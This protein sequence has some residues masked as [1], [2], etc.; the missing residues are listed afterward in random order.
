[1][2]FYQIKSKKYQ[3]LINFL[4]IA[5]GIVVLSGLLSV[6]SWYKPSIKL[7][8]ISPVTIVLD[9]D[10]MVIDKFNT[11]LARENARHEAIKNT[12]NK[13][14]FEIDKTAQEES[15]NKLK[16]AI[17]V[18]RNTILNIEPEPDPINPKVNIDA[19]N[20]FLAIDDD[21]FNELLLTDDLNALIEDKQFY[22]DIQI[23]ED[24]FTPLISS[25]IRRLKDI[26]LKYFFSELSDLRKQISYQEKI[27]SQLEK[28]FFEKIKQVNYESIFR[29]AFLVQ[30]KL[31]DLGIVRG[32]P[33]QKVIENIQILFPNIP[34]DN[35]ELIS[36]LINVTTLPNI[37]IDWQKVNELENEAVKEVKPILTELKSGSILAKKG[38]GI[39]EQNYYY[40]K[41]LNM[42]NP[43]TDWR[44]I[45]ENFAI[46]LVVSLIILIA[47]LFN[48]N[49]NFAVN[50]VAMIMLVPVAVSAIIAPV[51]VWG[52]SKLAL[53]PVATIS[54]LMTTF[55][56]PMMGLI[57]VNIVCFFLAKTIDMNFWQILPQYI[58]A[59]AAILF[60]RNAHQREDL[61]NAGTKIAIIQVS[62]F[63]LTIMLA[64]EDFKVTTVLIVASL[65]AIG[66]IASGFISVAALPYL[67]SGL[68][69]ITPF[70]LSELSNPNQP[71][72]KKLKKEAPGTYEHS[73]NVSRL[74]EEA[75]NALNL[76]TELI[77]VGL[78]YH[79][80]GKMHAPDYFIENTLGKPNPHTTLDNP[81]KSAEIIID[82][83][84]EGIKM[85]KKYNLPA[86]IVDFIPMHQGTT[87]TNFFYYKAIEN[88]GEKNVDKELFR[89]PGPKPN[90]KE[91]GVAMIADSSEAAL[92]SIKDIADEE[93]A[94]EMI[95]KIVNSRWEEGELN[96]SGLTSADLDVI[97]QSFLKVWR[98]QNHER[99][100]YPEKKEEPNEEAP[101]A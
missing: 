98:S 55:Y 78:L 22:K 77:R 11:K 15:F 33:K 47:A 53:A 62:I 76:N 95:R 64:V 4:I 85:A 17:K 8:R 90:S 10:V 45:K 63:L 81:I 13:E 71:L 79:D 20:F 96:E 21:K 46:I 14:I 30:K 19:Q 34:N 41:D 65:Y 26:E 99:V 28:N 32:L 37:Q 9:K 23:G 61:T 68:K 24:S 35:L 31:L 101:V 72:L 92:R 58:G 88:L 89:Y 43:K 80:I 75:S 1:M 82:H 100:K 50:R 40:L 84:P 52:V 49:T 16:F 7:N 83:V 39:S 29:Q 25:D 2:Q 59:I 87:V 5:I 27:K 38:E 97:A 66:A 42:L 44:E 12:A 54:I 93:K 51:A 48:K 73:L 86:A 3:L 56:S 94:E 70:K 74:S 6:R 36:S 69:L 18:V 91:T 57:A 67:E 60:T